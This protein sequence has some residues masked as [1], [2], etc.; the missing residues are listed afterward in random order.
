VVKE[1][2][3]RCRLDTA[4]RKAWWA[5]RVYRVRNDLKLRQISICFRCDPRGDVPQRRKTF[6]QDPLYKKRVTNN[7][8][9]RVSNAMAWKL[10]ERHESGSKGWR[11]PET[12][13]VTGDA[14]SPDQSLLSNASS[15]IASGESN[16]QIGYKQGMND[17]RVRNDLKLRF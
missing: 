10:I 2:L 3:V 13:S 4:G 12:A 9:C 6:A 17:H 14:G 1:E 7:R 8:L 11:S 5:G 15:K 16:Q